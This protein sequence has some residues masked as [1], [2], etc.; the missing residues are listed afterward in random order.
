[1]PFLI[2]DAFLLHFFFKLISVQLFP[3]FF[4]PLVGSS[5]QTIQAGG[6]GDCDIGTLVGGCDDGTLVGGCDVGTLVGGCDDGTLVGGCDVGT[7][8]GLDVDSDGGTQA[9][10]LLLPKHSA[11]SQQLSWLELQSPPKA[12]QLF[13][14]PLDSHILLLQLFS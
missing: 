7:L 11:G 3:F 8:V 1:M 4:I 14:A 12:T 10:L 13:L 5:S 6:V 9:A 2:Q